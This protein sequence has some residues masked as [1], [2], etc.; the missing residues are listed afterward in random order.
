M[1]SKGWF[2]TLF[3]AGHASAT[4]VQH[5]R[6]NVRLLYVSEADI[7]DFNRRFLTLTQMQAEFGIHRHTCAAN[8]KAAGVRPFAPDGQDFGALFERMKAE[9]VLRSLQ[10]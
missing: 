4:W 6:T 1:R 2:Q 9:P 10:P 5:P 3:E 8:L 7:A